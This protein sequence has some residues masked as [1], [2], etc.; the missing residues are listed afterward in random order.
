MVEPGAL[1]GNLALAKGVI[2]RNPAPQQRRAT[3]C[4][5]HGLLL[6][7]NAVNPGPEDCLTLSPDV[8]APATRQ[9]VKRF[10]ST[11]S[12]QRRAKLP[13]KLSP[14]AIQAIKNSYR[15]AGVARILVCVDFAFDDGTTI[16]LTKQ[17]SISPDKK[18]QATLRP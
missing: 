18:P 2:C 11:S 3:K 9:R 10:A 8:V 17:L 4:A 5:V 14:L 6:A 12:G 15:D 13:L 16:T 7:T 1:M